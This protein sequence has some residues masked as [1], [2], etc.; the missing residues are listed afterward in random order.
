MSVAATT[1]ALIAAWIY[2]LANIALYTT[3]STY[4]VFTTS[5]RAR[6]I[7][8]SLDHAMIYVLIAGT[9][10]PVCILAMTGSARW[11]VLAWMWAGAL[12]GMALTILA[13]ERFHKVTFA[14]YLVLGWSALAALP[15]LLGRPEHLTL[16]IAGGVLYT[17][18]AIL[19]GLKRPALVPDSFGYHEVWHLLGVTAGVL[20]FAVNLDLIATSA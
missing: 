12:V 15:A 2:G 18:G 5:P 8:Q 4:H 1:Q 17:V 20:L 11:V 10:T 19:F 13:L 3:S 6:R 7:M 14:M 9:F 16:V